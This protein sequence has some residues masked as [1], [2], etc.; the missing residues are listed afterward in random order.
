MPQVLCNII[1]SIGICILFSCMSNFGRWGCGLVLKLCIFRRCTSRSFKYITL[2]PIYFELRS[3]NSIPAFQIPPNTYM[4]MME[5]IVD[6]FDFALWEVKS[7][8]Y[9]LLISRKLKQV[10]ALCSTTKLNPDTRPIFLIVTVVTFCMLLYIVIILLYLCSF[11]PLP[12]PPE[13]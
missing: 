13:Y 5:K 6:S 3:R 7:R 2:L 4:N 1:V 9:R 8:N 12:T 10:L 11:R